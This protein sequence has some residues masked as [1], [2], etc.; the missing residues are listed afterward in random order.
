MTARL[1]EDKLAK[2]TSMLDNIY[3]R[4][5]YIHCWN[6]SNFRNGFP[7]FR[8]PGGLTG[9]DIPQEIIRR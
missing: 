9:P 4:S 3:L 6:F 8:V 2:I 5:H 1:L 7:Q